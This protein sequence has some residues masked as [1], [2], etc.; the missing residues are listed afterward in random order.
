MTSDKV[1]FSASFKSFQFSQS[2][3]KKTTRSTNILL[4]KI[5]NKMYECKILCSQSG[6]YE[7]FCL[8]GYN[9]I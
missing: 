8:L 1:S 6:G 7:E 2:N 3:K 4:M 9:T 5:M